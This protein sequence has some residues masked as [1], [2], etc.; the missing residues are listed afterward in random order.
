MAAPVVLVAEDDA[1]VRM[2]IEF[3]LE[4][5]GFEILMAS[6][7]EQAL[8]LARTKHPDVIL[9]DNLMPKMDGKAV[10]QA[11]RQDERT[12]SIPVLVMSGMSSGERGEWP[13]ARFVG[14]PFRP[15]DL[16]EEIRSAL[17]H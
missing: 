6:D 12:S 8:E 11:L 10:L 1:G 15:E 4:D 7:G 5:E 3:L 16:I 2:T 14:K 13:G 9:L 17:I